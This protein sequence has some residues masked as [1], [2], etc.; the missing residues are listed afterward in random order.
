MLKHKKQKNYKCGIRKLIFEKTIA[1]I[2]QRN[3]ITSLDLKGICKLKLNY[4]K[5]LRQRLD[6]E[7]EFRTHVDKIMCNIETRKFSLPW[8]H[9]YCCLCNLEM[10]KL[11]NKESKLVSAF[12]ESITNSVY[13]DT[14]FVS[15]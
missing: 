1:K 2:V 7:L 15:E 14:T 10:S 11:S 4:I 5:V 6:D 12:L 3:A 13:N 8:F 9:S